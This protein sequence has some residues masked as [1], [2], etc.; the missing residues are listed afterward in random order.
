[1]SDIDP[2]ALRKARSVAK[3]VTRMHNGVVEFDDI[4]SECFVWMVKNADKVQQWVDEGQPGMGRLNTALYR[5]AQ[6][7]SLRERARR[8]GTQQS[9]HYFYTPAVIE[10]LLPGLWDYDDWSY[11]SAVHDGSPRKPKAPSEGNDRLAMMVDLKWAVAGLPAEEQQLLRD[12]YEASGMELSML[13][14][15]NDMTEKGMRL[16]LN[17][18]ITK[19]CD[20]LGG[21]PPWY[22]GGRKAKSNARAQSET[23]NN[24]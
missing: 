19:L 12:R 8:S 18:I 7:Y 2:R 14:Y 16:K 6:R 17:R 10:A 22:T 24:E 4:L 20:R 15:R 9:D 13:A 1:M 23:R 5:A 21:E 3:R 11:Q